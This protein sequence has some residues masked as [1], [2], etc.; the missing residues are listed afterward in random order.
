MIIIQWSCQAARYLCTWTGWKMA[1]SI[2]RTSQ[3]KKSQ[4]SARESSNFWPALITHKVE[5]ELTQAKFMDTDHNKMHSDYLSVSHTFIKPYFVPKDD[6]AFCQQL[7]LWTQGNM[8]LNINIWDTTAFILTPY[9]NPYLI[10]FNIKSLLP[11]GI[12]WRRTPAQSSTDAWRNKYVDYFMTH[13]L[14][15]SENLYFVEMRRLNLQF[16]TELHSMWLCNTM[17]NNTRMSSQLLRSL[18]SSVHLLVAFLYMEICL[19]GW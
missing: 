10:S 7:V 17:K 1:C 11:E 16:I 3:K 13:T 5:I 8:P 14:N 9:T 4:V 18:F 19:L 2:D 15:Y 12:L 6:H